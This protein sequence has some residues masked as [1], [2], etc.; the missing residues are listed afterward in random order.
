MLWSRTATNP[1]W[2]HPFQ[3]PMYQPTKSKNDA[4]C[5]AGLCHLPR[6]TL[7]A[8]P[9][10]RGNDYKPGDAVAYRRGKMDLEYHLDK[11][12]RQKGR[13]TACRAQ[14][15]RIG[16]NLRNSTTLHSSEIYCQGE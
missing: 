8:L 5:L 12:V 16:G 1:A 11:I 14:A 9:P 4:R 13:L 3:E 2:H 6:P 10:V 15:E 7:R